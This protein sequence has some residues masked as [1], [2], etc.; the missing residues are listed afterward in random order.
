MKRK[1]NTF[2]GTVAN[3]ILRN[4]FLIIGGI[5]LLTVFFGTQ[6]KYM[7]FTFTEANLLPS[8]HPENIQYDTFIKTFGEEG[9]LIVIALKEEQF[10]EPIIFE[11]WIALNH[12]IESFTEI[13]FVLSINNVKELVKDESLK[14]FVLKSVFDTNDYKLND[15]KKFKQKLLLEL[16]FYRNILYDND[17]KTIRS[18]IYMDKNIVNTEKRKD[19]IFQTFIPLITAFEK[20]TGLDVKISGMPYIRTLNA[21]NILDEIGVFVV[22]A[23]LLTSLIFFLF[24]RS[25]RATFISMFVVIIGVMW[26][27]GILGLLRYEITILTAH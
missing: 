7:R 20:D 13:D 4:R 6:W 10:F 22:S 21:Q 24:F 12:K 17:G 27:F 5:I 15:I 11:K 3:L 25:F 1:K 23:V 26:A 16:P 9:N 8:N 19:F 2:W 18:A 14:S